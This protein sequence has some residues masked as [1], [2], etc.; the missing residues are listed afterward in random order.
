LLLLAACGP[1]ARDPSS[2]HPDAGAPA[3][4]SAAASRVYAHSGQT[5]YRLDALTLTASPI[6][7]MTGLPA[8]RDLL[9]L[10]VDS[11]DRLVGITRDKL[12]A[13]NSI[14]GE[15]TLMS[16]LSASAQGFTSLSF[17]PAASPT[18]PDLLV[19]ANDEGQVFELN[20]GVGTATM[21]GSYGTSA[22]GKVV[23]SGDLF[24][25]R[26]VGIFATVDVGGGSTDYLA[27][28]DPAQGWKATP[29]PNATGYD[30]VFGLGYWG[31]KIYGFVD[32]GYAASSG[33][34]IEIDPT[35]GVATQLSS[36]GVRWFGAGVTTHAPTFE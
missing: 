11:T 21:I 29:L 17:V 8:D 16:D 13:L 9:D 34:M 30:K 12:F 27:R 3:D 33:R 7:A 1:D 15:A 32:D 10:A 4:A 31:G 24:G 28:I 35:T 2:G 19:S 26:G 5:L 36:S 18:D 25:V 6:G 14:T 23:S 22:G 20:E